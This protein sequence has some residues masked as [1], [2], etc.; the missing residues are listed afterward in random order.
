MR[1]ASMYVVNPGIGTTRSATS[2]SRIVAAMLTAIS[3][4]SLCCLPIA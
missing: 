3:I 2:R 4:A 1:M